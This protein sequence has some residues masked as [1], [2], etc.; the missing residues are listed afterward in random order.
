MS[1]SKQAKNSVLNIPNES[2]ERIFKEYIDS[3]YYGRHL[4][5][6]GAL[7]LGRVCKT[8]RDAVDT[9]PKLWSTV[10]L[11]P[12]ACQQAVTRFAT[13]LSKTASLPIHIFFFD[14]G[15]SGGLSASV[16]G[17]LVSAL[18]GPI[19][20]YAHRLATLDIEM[21]AP[22]GWLPPLVL[23]LFSGNQYPKLTKVRLNI[24]DANIFAPRF[25][26]EGM[27]F[28][29]SFAK[30]SH[31]LNE[32][33]ACPGEWL[34]GQGLTVSKSYSWE[35]ITHLTVK[36]VESL[37]SILSPLRQCR[38]LESL[39][40]SFSDDCDQSEYWLQKESLY[41]DGAPLILNLPHLKELRIEFSDRSAMTMFN[42]LTLTNLETL[43]LTW[44]SGIPL[45][46]R[47]ATC[48]A[49]KKLIAR[50]RCFRAMLNLNYDG[51]VSYKS[52]AESEY[53]LRK[54]MLKQEEYF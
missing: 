9:M 54:T 14:A 19:S 4:E 49:L 10:Y 38:D 36:P 50:S 1:S 3:D 45:V 51:E 20:E 34:L 16:T 28:W 33:K 8:W 32:L 7:K 21:E 43:G 39:L 48:E 24:D 6:F 30:D 11:M 17:P 5:Q 42:A 23:Q 41:R 46:D 53:V 18:R 26:H 40:V 44:Y 29:Y 31:H 37:R 27:E 35:Q 12:P 2:L 52:W 25:Y 13:I 47:R 22:P 15:V